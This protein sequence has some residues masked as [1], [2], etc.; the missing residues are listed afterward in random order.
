MEKTNFEILMIALH[1][2]LEKFEDSKEFGNILIEAR[3]LSDKLCTNNYFSLSEKV[4]NF[5]GDVISHKDNTELSLKQLAGIYNDIYEAE[6]DIRIEDVHKL[7]DLI[8]T[9]I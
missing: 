9:L 3:E 7:F 5:V 1:I 4:S 2:V 6:K 8:I